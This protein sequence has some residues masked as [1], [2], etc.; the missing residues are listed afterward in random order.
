[1][2]LDLS[3]SFVAGAAVAGCRFAQIGA[4]DQAVIQAAANDDVILGV[5]PLSAK[6]GAPVAVQTGLVADL[7][8]GAAITRGAK[9]TSNADGRG[10]TASGTHEVGGIALTAGTAPVGTVFSRIKILVTPGA[11]V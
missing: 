5:F 10:V 11:K 7:E 4:A 8:V 9:V 2:V 1:M 3:P 6:S